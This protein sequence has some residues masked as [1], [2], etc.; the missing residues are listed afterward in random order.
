[1][2]IKHTVK[3]GRGAEIRTDCLAVAIFEDGTMSEAAKRVDEACG[4]VIQHLIDRGDAQGRLEK[5]L[6]VPMLNAASGGARARRL[7]LFGLGKHGKVEPAG[8][9]RAMR[10]VAGAANNGRT[11]SVTIDLAGVSVDGMGQA[12]LARTAV[13]ELE[14]ACYRFDEMKS[15][16]ADDDG[17]TPPR[18]L[19]IMAP[20]RNAVRRMRAGAATGAAISAG[21]RLSR[22]LGNL[23]G[24]VCT[25]SYL[26]RRA[27]ALQR[28]HGLKV[29]VLDEARMKQL[30]MGA[31]LSVARGSRE[32]AKLIVME[33]RGGARSEPPVALV[34]KGLTFD[35]GGI[36]LK[37]AANMDEMKY[38]M[39][40]AA[41]VFGTLV[42][43]AELK[44]PV[45][46][47]GVV[48]SSENLPDGA[49]NKPGD[50]VRSMSGKTIEIL[51]TDAE[52]R[53][54]LCDA[55]T[56]VERYKP[57]VV[58]DLATLT[59]ACVVAL[60]DQASGLFS[61]DDRLAEALLEAGETSRDRAWRLPL[62]DEYQK[63]I[64]SPFADVANIG[65]RY[66]G[67][68]TAACFLARFTENMTWA[69]LDIAGT[70]WLTGKDKGATGRPVPLLT[71]Y[72]LNRAGA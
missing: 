25:P 21:V 42:A 8:Y 63:Q 36:S 5:T 40:G 31:L 52:G 61:R 43:I 47:V 30:G 68:I 55:L 58:I 49:A 24:N 17:D 1:M 4:G 11:A 60:G 29:S 35:A 16:R 56:Y 53:L 6:S 45:N 12:D 2:S 48:P 10:A 28:S 41:G 65:G 7:L 70:A 18:S 66:G 44:L 57:A 13:E 39:C 9:R 50:I 19:T 27:R 71:Q 67:A 62:W 23:P 33:Y 37:P 69:H 72:L 38:D 3:Q 14:S 22:D 26:A 54:I 34:G 59:G 20:D 15:K 46:V 64:D 32:P 51:N